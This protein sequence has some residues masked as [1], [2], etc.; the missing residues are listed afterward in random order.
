MSQNT[1]YDDLNKNV[2]PW[3]L[4][5]DWHII[6]TSRYYFERSANPPITVAQT[7]L[8]FKSRFKSLLDEEQLDYRNMRNHILLDQ[9]DLRIV[10]EVD[11]AFIF[12]CL[13]S[14][15]NGRV[16]GNLFVVS[17]TIDTADELEEDGVLLIDYRG[18]YAVAIPIGLAEGDTAYEIVKRVSSIIKKYYDDDDDEDTEDSPVEDPSGLISC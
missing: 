10:Y 12:I 6:K 1:L 8:R 4:D 15:E 11:E 3:P 5:W 9:I 13:F 17:Y 14:L 18:G 7:Y 16:T 2:Q